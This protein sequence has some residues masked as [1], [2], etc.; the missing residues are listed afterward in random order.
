[1]KAELI[2]VGDELLIGQVINT[3]AAWIGEQC[4]VMGADLVRTV[5][6]GDVIDDIE[7]ALSYASQTADLIVITGGLGP[8]H[9][10]VTKDAV[11]R[12]F[13]V[14]LYPD[15]EVQQAIAARFA[16]LGR[17]MSP[18]NRS[19]ALVPEGF[20][21]L[22]N[23][24][25]TA[26]GLWWS[27][28]W[29][30]RRL[31][32]TILPGVPHEMEYLF[33]HE[34]TPRIQ[35]VKGLRVIQHRT[36]LTSG[37]GESSLQDRIGDLTGLLGEQLRL[38]Y[39]PSSSGV[40][41][42][43]TAYGSLPQEVQERLDRMEEY[44]RHRIDKFIYG[45][46]TDTLERVV[47]D[48]LK[49]H[50]LKIAVAESC[51]GGYVVNRLTNISGASAVVIGGVIAYCNR[52]KVDLLGVD[53]GVLED[54]GAVSEAVALQMAAGIRKRLGADIGISVTGIAGPTGGT[55][56]KPVGTVWIGYSDQRETFAQLLHLAEERVLNKE[57]ASTSILTL[58]YRRLSA[59]LTSAV[60]LEKKERI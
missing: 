31:L 37:I 16:R 1:M 19:Q 51:T 26:P 14:G 34:V 58:L 53:P 24:V 48:Q 25:G 41:L 43:M 17:A 30:G 11:A 60:T 9:D 12:F 44:L 55:P 28:E 57:L 7:R 45:T 15:E 56:E 18:S 6:V 23:P 13:G 42:R 36:L 21:V 22:A 4:S 3:N 10:D 40:R 49:H 35:K 47:L 52:V 5:V 46:N 33:L 32:V 39:L 50:G 8:T 38:A 27:G 54:E 59:D 2:T 29:N 20:T